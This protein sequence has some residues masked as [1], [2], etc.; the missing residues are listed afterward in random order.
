MQ[1]AKS[2]LLTHYKPFLTKELKPYKL[3]FN[4]IIGFI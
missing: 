3:T 2:T 1:L 4:S